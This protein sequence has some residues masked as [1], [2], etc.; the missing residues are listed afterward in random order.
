MNPEALNLLDLKDVT[1][2]YGSA[3]A[4]DACSLSFRAGEVHAL[5]GANEPGKVRLCEWLQD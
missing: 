3:K 1:K 4:V 5:L 2:S